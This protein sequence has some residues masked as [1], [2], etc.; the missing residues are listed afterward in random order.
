MLKN[1][2]I[3]SLLGKIE[4]L[5]FFDDSPNRSRCDSLTFQEEKP[6]PTKESISLVTFKGMENTDS[7]TRNN[8]VYSLA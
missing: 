2:E 3:E 4:R 1:C 7:H 6:R 8:S 5:T